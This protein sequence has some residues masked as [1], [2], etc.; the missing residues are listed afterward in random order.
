MKLLLDTHVFLW[1]MSAPNKL[2]SNILEMLEQSSNEVFLSPA[3]SW[4]SAIKESMGK[5]T[6]PSEPRRYVL[7][8]M[9]EY[10]I[11]ALP[12]EHEHTLKTRELPLIHKDPFDR[13]LIAQALCENLPLI[14]DDILIKQ[15]QVSTLW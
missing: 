11:T 10:S 8:R 14:T 13:L 15:Y 4:E 7:S 5:L 6:L 12:I 3:S 1:W 2:R 9:I